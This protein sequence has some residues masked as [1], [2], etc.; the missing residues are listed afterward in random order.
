MNDIKIKTNDIYLIFKWSDVNESIILSINAE[1]IHTYK[2][3][4]CYLDQKNKEFKLW[5]IF[6]IIDETIDVFANVNFESSY[7]YD[8]FVDKIDFFVKKIVA[9]SQK[10]DK[11]RQLQKSK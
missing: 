4:M 5:I 11:K 8:D 3:L 9:S 6:E 1:E 7:D 10:K 2:N